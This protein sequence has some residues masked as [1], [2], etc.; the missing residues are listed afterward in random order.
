MTKYADLLWD[1]ESLAAWVVTLSTPLIDPETMAGIAQLARQSCGADSVQA[2]TFLAGACADVLFTLPEADPWRHLSARVVSPGSTDMV[3]AAP[4]PVPETTGAASARGAFGTWRDGAD[5]FAPAHQNLL[6]D[7]Y[8]A[9]LATALP[10]A[11]AAAL[12]FAGAS[13]SEGAQALLLARGSGS[14]VFDIGAPA[15]R[16]AMWRRWA[17]LGDADDFTYS[18]VMGWLV[19]SGPVVSTGAF[20]DRPEWEAERE[21]ARIPDDEYRPVD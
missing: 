20:P 21:A 9:P 17:Y 5:L 15:L 12:A 7:P 16:W 3:R 2:A 6:V 10:P 19:R 13:Y 14:V 4:A 8:L 11:S 18:A 1:E